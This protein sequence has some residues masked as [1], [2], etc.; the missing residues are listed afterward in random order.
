MP[1]NGLM[2]RTLLAVVTAVLISLMIAPHRGGNLL[3]VGGYSHAP[4]FVA[5]PQ[6]DVKQLVLQTIFLAGSVGRARESEAAPKVK[7]KHVYP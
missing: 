6:V 5:S 7:A 4:I 1:N 3:R 2:E